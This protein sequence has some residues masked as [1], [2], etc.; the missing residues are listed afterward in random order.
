MKTRNSIRAEVI[1]LYKE[2]VIKWLADSVKNQKA[3]EGIRIFLGAPTKDEEVLANKAEFIAFCED[4]HKDIISG[5]VDFLKKKYKDIGEI[6]VPIHLVFDKVDDIATWAG[7]LVEFHSAQT[8]LQAIKEEL[9]ELIDAGIDNINSLTTMDDDDFSRFVAV[10]KWLIRNKR[11]HALIRQIPVRGVDTSWFEEHRFYILNLMRDY[12]KLNPLRKDLLQLGLIPPPQTIRIVLLDKNLRAKLGG[13]RDVGLTVADLSKLEIAPSKV[14]FFDDLS[15]ALSLPDVQSTVAIVLPRRISGICSV[16]WVKKAQTIYM[17]GI[18]MRAF[19]ILNN[20]R[21]YLP[22]TQCLTLHKDV[23]IADRDLWSFDDIEI[24][25]LNSS[26]ALTM[27]ETILYN[28]L[29]A[30]VFGVCARLPQERMPLTQIFD[31]LQI[32]YTPQE[33]TSA[34]TNIVEMVAKNDDMPPIISS[35][36][37]S[38][39]S[40]A[41]PDTLPVSTPQ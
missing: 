33:E 18:Q 25:E 20:L 32:P 1:A 2:K 21:V 40:A 31:L 6:E 19:A 7:H 9:P 22:K 29:A 27:D 10:C 4:W 17:S 41:D 3:V 38:A 12:L 15:T 34:P 36:D 16:P 28:M 26:M 35:S 24:Q 13:L 23:F 37:N 30:G 11:S 5:K 14:I 8:R 39:S